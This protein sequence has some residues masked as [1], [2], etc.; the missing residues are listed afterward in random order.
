[1]PHMTKQELREDP[2]LER[3]QGFLRLA[4]KNTR[5][6]IGAAVVI[7][8]IIVGVTMVQR[9]KVRGEREA[10]TQLS[11]AQ[12]A[13]LQGNLTAAESGFRQIVD[14]HGGT[15]SGRVARVYLADV[16]QAMGRSQDALKLYEDASGGKNPVLEV[17]ALRGQA[18]ALE[19]LGRFADASKA[20]E[21]AA[22]K[23]PFLQ[24]EDLIS[25]GRAA[26]KGGDAARAKGFF[27]Q[28]QKK[29]QGDKQAEVALLLAE[30]EAALK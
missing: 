20:Y 9:G 30:A 28:A 8:A 15:S 23:A 14:S 25:A 2:I 26:L 18:A 16:L 3:I 6:L 1:M 22:A 7:V 12:G 11:E 21:H 19:D 10:A 4:E 17:A 24:T 5:W 27:E 13:Y 29:T